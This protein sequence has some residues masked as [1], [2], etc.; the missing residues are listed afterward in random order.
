MPFP[1]TVL[2]MNSREQQHESAPEKSTSTETQP[3]YQ[4]PNIV[5]IPCHEV[6]ECLF[7]TDSQNTSYI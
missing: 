4:I 6:F 2:N 5:W 3:E 7:C 1:V